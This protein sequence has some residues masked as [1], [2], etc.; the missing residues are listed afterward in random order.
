MQNDECRMMITILFFANLREIAGVKSI[1]LELP[2]GAS[3]ADMKMLLAGRM[4]A[5][6]PLMDFALVSIN[7]EYAT[8]GQVIP[9]QA[10]IAIFPPVSGG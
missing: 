4:P 6:K 9:E 7:R 3:V 5:L 10:E 8:D 1:A 2:V